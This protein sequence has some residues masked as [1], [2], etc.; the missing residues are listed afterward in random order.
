M[1]LKL[2]PPFLI[3]F[4]SHPKNPCFI[5]FF[6]FVLYPFFSPQNYVKTT[7]P[8]K[9]ETNPA[10]P[11][12]AVKTLSNVASRSPS[13]VVIVV[14]VR[15]GKGNSIAQK[16]YKTENLTK[17]GRCQWSPELVKV[18]QHL[19]GIFG[20]LS[21]SKCSTNWTLY[22]Q[23]P[24]GFMGII[25]WDKTSQSP[26]IIAPHAFSSW[27]AFWKR[28]QS[29]FGVASGLRFVPAETDHAICAT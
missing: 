15:D 8:K 23:I 24:V 27:A 7:H 17:I 5:C 1:L 10:W 26:S 19:R 4:V 3:H 21:T 12:R 16:S 20:N 14:W 9:N 6:V 2:V 29:G 22:H 28:L 13:Q 18:L 25:R 11:R